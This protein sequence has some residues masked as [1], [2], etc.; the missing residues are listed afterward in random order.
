M[1]KQDFDPTPLRRGVELLVE[2]AL[3]ALKSGV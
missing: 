1:G 2:A 3:T